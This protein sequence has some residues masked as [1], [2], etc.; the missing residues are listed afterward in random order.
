MK[1]RLRTIIGML[2]AAAFITTS[3]FA[4]EC[5]YPAGERKGR[6]YRE[7][8]KEFM[9][10]LNL[11]PEQDRLLKDVKTA[12]REEAKKLFQALKQKREELKSAL[13]KPDATQSGVA[14][15]MAEIK[16]LQ[17]ELLDYRIEGIFKIKSILTPEQFQKLESLKNEHWKKAHK[18]HVHEKERQR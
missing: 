18:K 3:A 15:I 4:G 12:H 6:D 13:A 11:T 2:I 14:P 5:G 17:A 7:K 16:K 1:G 9:R 10:E 8:K